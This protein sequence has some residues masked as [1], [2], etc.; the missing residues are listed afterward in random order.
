MCAAAVFAAPMGSMTEQNQVEMPGCW[1]LPL[2]RG[3]V[4]SLDAD[5]PAILG[6]LNVT[7][8]SFSDG[9]C[10]ATADDAARAGLRLL[11]EGA[12]ALDIGGE[13]TR[14]GSQ[15]V[16]VAEQVRRVVPVID[17]LRSQTDVPL[18]VDTASPEVAAAAIEAGVDIVN[19]VNGFRAPGWPEVLRG[20]PVS[21]IA[22][23]MQGTPRDMQQNPTYP[24]GVS[25]AV[26]SFFAERVAAL[27]RWGVDSDRVI[28]DPGVGFGK[29]LQHNLDLIRNIENLR[30]CERPLLVGLSRKRFIGTVLDRDVDA[31]DVGT[32]AANAA[33]LFAGANILRV[34]NVPYTRDL[35]LM[36]AAIRSADGAED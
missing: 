19:D 18:S 20:Q 33:A 2:P 8:D 11:E 23:H 14:P 22:M 10:Y 13:S 28:L 21:V 36:I 16:P 12:D 34:H 17:A 15:S 32:V 5:R 3:R 6:V 4:W 31:R 35:A 24:E 9:G 1:V 25:R 27:E 29:V 30:V 26:R 7:P